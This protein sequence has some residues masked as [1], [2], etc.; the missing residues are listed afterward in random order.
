MGRRLAGRLGMRFADAD[1]EIERAADMTI[2]D[3]FERF[4]EAHFATASGG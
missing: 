3:I 1:D 4:G 2:A